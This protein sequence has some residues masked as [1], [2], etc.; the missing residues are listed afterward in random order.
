MRR[1]WC[2]TV[3]ASVLYIAVVIATTEHRLGVKGGSIGRTTRNR[4]STAEADAERGCK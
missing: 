4:I 3:T 2:P 1:K